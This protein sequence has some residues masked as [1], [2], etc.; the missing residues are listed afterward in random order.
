MLKGYPKIPT[1][2][3]FFVCLIILFGC[4]PDN[5]QGCLLGSI[6]CEVKDDEIETDY[7]DNQTRIDVKQN[8]IPQKQSFLNY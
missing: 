6:L 4:S 7:S 5:N 3:T 8:P 2:V 1:I